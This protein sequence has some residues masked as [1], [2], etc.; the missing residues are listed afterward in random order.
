MKIRQWKSNSEFFIN[1]IPKNIQDNEKDSIKVI[2]IDWNIKAD[3]LR[4]NPKFTFL[5]NL[6]QK[7]DDL[8][9]QKVKWFDI[10]PKSFCETLDL[11]RIGLNEVK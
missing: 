7:E 3:K 9:K 8:W 6:Q 1:Q 4:L 2:G 5:K 10:I 11:I